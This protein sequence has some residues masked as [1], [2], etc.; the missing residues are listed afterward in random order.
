MEH[1]GSRWPLLQQ[2]SWR[3]NCPA[4]DTSQ[5]PTHARTQSLKARQRTCGAAE[6]HTP[7]MQATAGTH[8]L[9][10]RLA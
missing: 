8:T 5:T 6:G 4:T 1:D 3:C 2:T 7:H 9:V 10:F